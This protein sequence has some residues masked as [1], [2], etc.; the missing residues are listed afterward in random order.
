MLF[1]ESEKE[2]EN[3]LNLISVLKQT[4][5]YDYIKTDLFSEKISTIQDYI[6]FQKHNLLKTN[7]SKYFSFGLT[8]TGLS[9]CYSNE[10]ILE[11]PDEML[12]NFGIGCSLFGA[13]LSGLYFS[14][15]KEDKN[16]INYLNNKKSDLINQKN[17]LENK[18]KKE[19][20]K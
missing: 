14:K 11:N 15:H 18:L 10:Y 6:N 9:I 8:I 20:L 1:W 7:I 16:H 5:D 2:K 4:S 13:L 17:N 12:E 19:R 3:Y